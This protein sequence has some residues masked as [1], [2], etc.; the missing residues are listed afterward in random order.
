MHFILI[1]PVLSD[2]L[3]CVNL[4]QC[5]LE[6]HI[7]QIWLYS[8]LHSVI[9][10]VSD[11]RHVGGFLRVLRFPPPIFLPPQYSWNIAESGVKQHSP[12]FLAMQFYIIPLSQGFVLTVPLVYF[13]YI[14]PLS[15]CFALTVT[16]GYFVCFIPLSQ[17]LVL[18]PSASQFKGPRPRCMIILT[19][20]LHFNT[21]AVITYCTL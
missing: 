16:L 13:V 19:L 11:L 9:K 21:Y 1:K 3:S 5:S 6:G 4:F 8:I 17:C 20:L 14:I 10:F 12:S 15:Q 7:R 2:H 18:K